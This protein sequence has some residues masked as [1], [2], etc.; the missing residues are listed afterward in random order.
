MGCWKKQVKT[1]KL[2]YMVMPAWITLKWSDYIHDCFS[3]VCVYFVCVQVQS[4]KCG[5][6]KEE[7]S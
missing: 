1:G 2:Q 6:A 4:M 5:E 3:V 7:V